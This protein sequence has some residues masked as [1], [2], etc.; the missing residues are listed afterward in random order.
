MLLLFLLLWLLPGDLPVIFVLIGW[1][2]QADDFVYF[3]DDA[4]EGKVHIR[5]VESGRLYEGQLMLVRIGR[6][7]L[8][9]NFSSISQIGLVAH[10]QDDYVAICVLLQLAEPVCHMFERGH[11]R[12]IVYKE[13][14]HG[15]AVVGVCDGSVALLTCSVP[16]LCLHHMLILR[17]KGL[18]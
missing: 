16:Y 17:L 10:Q 7:I 4:V 5:A 14:R 11:A 13:C 8:L 9:S 3:V 1:G 6:R 15:P 18:R 2:A 12:H